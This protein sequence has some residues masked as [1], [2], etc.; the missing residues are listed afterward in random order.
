MKKVHYLERVEQIRALMDPLR[1]RMIEAMVEG[2]T[3][4][5]QIADAVG[6]SVPKIHYHL[7]DLEKH[8]LIE[9]T[10][11][12]QKGNLLENHYRPLAR[13]FK[14]AAS[15]EKELLAS[16]GETQRDILT[17]ALLTIA[18]VVEDRIVET[19]NVI[20]SCDDAQMANVAQAV[21]SHGI[22]GE[23]KTLYLT[24]E[25]YHEFHEEYKAL[26]AK[27]ADKRKSKKRLSVEV[28]LTSYPDV[29][30]IRKLMS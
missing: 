29:D 3:T 22:M 6:G 12:E 25:E 24:K 17:R 30:A 18:S 4:S 28:F 19:V 7:K 26:I 9:V 27:Y 16:E 21:F 10:K 13:N 14:M 1:L 20:E 8:G 15:V 5:R 11:Q 2:A 23:G